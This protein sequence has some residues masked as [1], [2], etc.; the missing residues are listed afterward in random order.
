MIHGR[1]IDCVVQDESRLI[2]RRRH[3]CVCA[4][5]DHGLGQQNT[6]PVLHVRWIAVAVPRK[7]L[8]AGIA[9]RVLKLGTGLEQVLVNLESKMPIDVALSLSS[10]KT[11][12]C[13]HAK[14]TIISHNL[15]WSAG[16][17][18]ITRM[19]TSRLA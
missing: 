18:S 8:L 14:R 17:S 9:S 1:A 15:G 6:C 19:A 2:V 11:S 4:C 10:R 16:G 7:L 12:I 13:L 3:F 5:G